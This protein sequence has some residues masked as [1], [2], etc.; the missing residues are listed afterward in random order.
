MKRL[1]QLLLICMCVL[2]AQPKPK[3]VESVLSG[4]TPRDPE[5]FIGIGRVDINK[6]SRAEYENEGKELALI[7]IS[8]QIKT[9]V[10]GISES[11]FFEDQETMVDRFQ[12]KSMTITFGDL[13]GL[14]LYRKFST[15]D[16]Y[17]VY[18]R[19]NKKSHRENMENC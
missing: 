3:W 2:N 6:R 16:E 14:E 15:S 10:I 5:Y 18:Y 12:A 13:E 4:E 9:Q 17:F 1:S 8:S 11:Y 19:L 7:D